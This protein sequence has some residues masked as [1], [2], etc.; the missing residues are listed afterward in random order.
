MGLAVV[1]FKPIL[2]IFITTHTHLNIAKT[3]SIREGGVLAVTGSVSSAV[4][5]AVQI[6]PIMRHLR[7]EGGAYMRVEILSCALS[8]RTEVEISRSHVFLKLNKSQ[9]SGLYSYEIWQFSHFFPAL[10]LLHM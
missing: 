8:R 5:N 2:P 3:L 9:L 4:R 6:T 7:S 10:F 1:Q